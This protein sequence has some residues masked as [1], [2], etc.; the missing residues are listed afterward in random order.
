MNGLELYT[1]SNIYSP[2]KNEADD[3]PT[4]LDYITSI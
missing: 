4:N 2:F 3:N 1:Q